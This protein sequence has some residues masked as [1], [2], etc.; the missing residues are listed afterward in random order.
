MKGIENNDMTSEQSR[1]KSNR[2]F[3]VENLFWNVNEKVPSN[4]QN[5]F[6]N[7]QESWIHF[8]KK[9]ALN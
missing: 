3:R 4:N 9:N 8:D 6:T 2:N 1:S 7:F 5:Q